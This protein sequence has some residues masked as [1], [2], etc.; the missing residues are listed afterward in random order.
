MSAEESRSISLDTCLEVTKF[1]TSLVEDSYVYPKSSA[2]ILNSTGDVYF[3]RSGVNIIRE[4][5]CCHPVAKLIIDTLEKHHNLTGDGSKLYIL[6]IHEILLAIKNKYKCVTLKTEHRIQIIEEISQLMYTI[7]PPVF[8]NL[9]ENCP[10]HK[11]SV[12][13]GNTDDIV[14]T[15]SSIV[16][17]FFQYKFTKPISKHLSFVIIDLICRSVRDWKDLSFLLN[18]LISNFS[19]LCSK[20]VASVQDSCVLEGIVISKTASKSVNQVFNNS[21]VIIN[22]IFKNTCECNASILIQ[23]DVSVKQSVQMNYRF[24]MHV[25]CI[26]IEKNI[27]VLI[28]QDNIP[29]ELASL[30]TEKG[31][32]FLDRICEVELEHVVWSTGVVPLHDFCEGIKPENIG[33]FNFIKSLVFGQHRYIHIGLPEKRDGIVHHH[34]MLAAPFE[35][36]YKECYRECINSLKVIQQWMLNV[37]LCNTRSFCS[38]LENN[39]TTE[40][41]FNE[42]VLLA[43][44]TPHK[45]HE[46]E[47]III[48]SFKPVPQKEEGLTLVG[49]AYP[50]GLWE[51]QV[52]S[53]L[54]SGTA[55]YPLLKDSILLVALT[56]IIRKRQNIKTFLSSH[57]QQRRIGSS[58]KIHNFLTDPHLETKLSLNDIS[59]EPVAGKEMLIFSVL[60]VIT[61]LI[62][63]NAVVS[64]R[65]LHP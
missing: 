34:I 50:V 30:C 20:G 58:K 63:L 40:S 23:N 6:M 16:N 52:H 48:N 46:S 61:Q 17:T 24:Y 31:I 4:T 26:L 28:S 10:S 19:V 55:S 60:N 8:V 54:S 7:L 35:S 9:R 5:Y 22:D 57:S 47:I 11:F 39:G 53:A 44:N 51:V 36:L 18:C 12:G 38:G 62:R 33:Q 56:Q 25:L 21:F 42:S 45:G 29:E 27:S 65:Q 37:K 2:L 32:M 15:I 14:K 13:T 1:L 41:E 43:W 64:V 49:V 3:T 59:L